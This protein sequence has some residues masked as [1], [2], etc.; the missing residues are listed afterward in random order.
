MPGRLRRFFESI[1][2]AGLKPN[3]PSGDPEG[4]KPGGPRKLLD[5]LFARRAPADPFYL[6]NRTWKQRLMSGLVIGISC[7]LLAGAVTLGLS[8]LYAPKTEPTAAEIVAHLLPDLEK[9]IDRTPKQA[10][11]LDLRPDTA[12]SPK[13]I[14]TLR[15]HTDRT[16]SVEFTVDLTDGDGSKLEAVTERVEKAPAK[17][18]VPFQ[19][20]IT[21]E[22]AAIAVVRS[23]RV[24]D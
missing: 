20:P 23:L 22:N 3:A 11:I 4:G 5:R 12:G 8:Y 18:D 9:T 21:D 16:I 13:I 15:N 24:V 1:A 7:V 17:T 6:T 2:Y 10:E 19:F 14:G